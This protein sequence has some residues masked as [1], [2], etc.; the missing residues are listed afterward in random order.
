MVVVSNREPYEHRWGED[1]G[2]IRVKRP[3][4]GLTSALDPL[5]QAVGGVWIAWGSGD[6][7]AAV[8]DEE[9]RVRVPP[10]EESYTLRRIWLDQ[11]DVNRYYLGFANQFLWP[12]CHYRPALTRVRSRYWERYRRVNRRFADAVL[13]E[14]RGTD[15]VVWF[16]DYHLALAP[17]L[18]R[19]RRP[20][21]SLAHFWHIPWPPLEIF[22]VSPQAEDLL[23]GLLANDLLGF[24]LPSHQEHF[25]HCAEALLGVA[26]DRGAGTATVDDHV[27]HVRSFPISID[28]DTFIRDATASGAEE[29]VDRLRERYC[30]PGG[31]LALGVDR[32][33][34]SKGLPEKLKAFDFLW[35]RYPE[36]RGRLTLVQVG[37]PSR[38]DIEAYDELTQK[39]ERLVWEINDRYGTAEWQPV[40]LI[41]QSLPADRLAVLYRAADLC[42]VASLRDGMN[43]VAKEF[44]ASQV[45]ERGVLLLSR[46]A[47]AAAELRHAIQ[48]NP[49]DP[50]DFGRLLRDALTMPQEERARRIGAMRRELR[51]IY[52]W[53]AEIFEEWGGI[54]GGAPLP[55]DLA[56]AIPDGD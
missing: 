15:S 27:C 6:A 25:L 20:D 30:P 35:E 16:Q 50:E 39:V 22:E 1:V 23:G 3:A 7:D 31:Q 5:L 43:L 37:V 40:H 8:V 47:G 56:A 36:Y 52:D 26:V 49:Y 13:D 24:Q 41:K 51:S 48:V 28:I 53:M 54:R 17:A 2:E 11:H 55:D 9:D 14:T 32:M 38:T 10:E 21:L 45:D 42:V 34:Y 46:F 44:V 4:G 19:A 33:D 29:S 18:V 12:L